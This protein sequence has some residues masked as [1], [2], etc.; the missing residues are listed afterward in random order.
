[1]EHHCSYHQIYNRSDLLLL[2][3]A[4]SHFTVLSTTLLLALPFLVLDM[5]SMLRSGVSDET[6]SVLQIL[7]SVS[8]SDVLWSDTN[9]CWFRR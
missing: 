6:N 4:Q 3:T 7:V 8:G 2:A 1:M 9:A 5:L